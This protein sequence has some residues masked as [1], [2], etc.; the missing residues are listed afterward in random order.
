MAGRVILPAPK[1]V[2]TCRVL[3]RL[4]SGCL[5]VALIAAACGSGGD[6][7]NS[8][9]LGIAAQGH[10]QLDAARGYYNDVLAQDPG[11]HF[12]NNKFA[13]FN[14]GVIDQQ[15]NKSAA[16]ATEYRKSLLIDPNYLGALYNLAIVET[17]GA[18]QSA[19]LLYRQ[20]L[21]L[22]PH[23]TNTLYNLGLLL[24]ETGQIDEGKSLLHQ[25]IQLAPSLASKVPSSVH[26]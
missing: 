22:K 11:N 6:A 12:G 3:P 14:L 21:A 10:G 15:Q 16:A 9:R 18:P 26:L 23:D 4:L 13:Y 25:A 1:R 7:K 20:I 24:Y 2:R 5:A 19:V 17:P 8:F